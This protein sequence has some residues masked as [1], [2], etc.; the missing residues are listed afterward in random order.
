[1]C[2]TSNEAAV[3]GVLNVVLGGRAKEVR[4]FAG[5]VVQ[6]KKPAPDVYLLAAKEL[7]VMNHQCVVIEDTE[8][9]CKAAKRARMKCVV[10]F[11]GCVP[12]APPFRRASASFAPDARGCA[13]TR[14]TRTSS[15]PKRTPCSTASAR[16]VRMRAGRRCCR[17]RADAATLRALA[18]HA[19]FELDDLTVPNG[20]FWV[21]DEGINVEKDDGIV[22][23][24]SKKRSKKK[25]ASD[26]E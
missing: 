20:A 23:T 12:A 3:Q 16:L 1:V 24:S 21:D 9:G 6:N 4:V 25:A 5:D 17:R 22:V 11:N 18:G 15:R 14:A 10:T 19:N 26:D 2:S 13:A 8:I 7:D